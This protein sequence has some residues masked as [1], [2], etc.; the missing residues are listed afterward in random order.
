MANLTYE[1]SSALMM[2]MT[3][4]GRIKVACLSFAN[5]II[6]EPNSMPAHN[7]RLAWAKNCYQMPD[8]V[9]TQVQPPTVMEDSVQAAGSEIDD[10]ALQTA[11]ENAINKML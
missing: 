1:Q 5:Y 3:F 9:A 8:T 2:D 10:V 11:V 4:R 6:G 7:T